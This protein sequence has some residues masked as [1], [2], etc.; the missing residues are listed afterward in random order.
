MSTEIDLDSRPSTYFR[1]QSL[2]RHL[3][4][5]VKGAVLKQKLQALF[6]E[7]RHA[8]VKE[9]LGSDGISAEDAKSLE[10][11]H[12][13]FM[14]GNYLPDA[15][16]GEVEIARISLQSTTF[17][18]ASIN[19]CLRE[20]IIHYR[21]V[22]EYEGDTLVGTTEFESEEPLSLGKIT[23]LFMEAWT[24]IDVLEM[25]FDNDLDASLD[26]FSATS[27]FYPDFDR[28]CRR[29]V[30]EHFRAAEAQDLDETPGSDSTTS[31]SIDPPTVHLRA[32]ASEDALCGEQNFSRWTTDS[33]AATCRNCWFTD[34]VGSSNRISGG[35]DIMGMEVPAIEAGR[36][37]WI[38]LGALQESEPGRWVQGWL[39]TRSSTHWELWLHEE[40]SDPEDQGRRSWQLP[41]RDAVE[42]ITT[43]FGVSLTIGP[44]RSDVRET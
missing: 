8:E 21:I 4:S 40:G 23:D 2:E 13:M 33:G 19:A 42:R 35:S 10:A 25:N 29:R 36:E 37:G 16:D 3:I 38:S 9:L 6:D 20:G 5:T 1:P 43:Q 44:Q 28:L 18:V 39:D 41:P 7:G 30:T 12:P 26:F 27:D 34:L 14:G 32:V 31:I 17:D 15:E 24:L 22:D 11:I